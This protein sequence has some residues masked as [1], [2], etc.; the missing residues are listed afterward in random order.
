M[1]EVAAFG[2]GGD[3][4][5]S[6]LLREAESWLDSLA[7]VLGE[8][9]EARLEGADST[10]TVRAEVSGAGRLLGLTIDPRR[11]RD[12]DHV[13][14]AEAVREAIVAAHVAMGERLVEMADGLASPAAPTS[15]GD[16]L[17]SYVQNV[18]RGD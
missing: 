12:L 11:L 5:L 9:E 15:G 10:G 4:D 16:P 13:E 18:L 6:G 2:A 7:G 17:D 14:L 3:G 8:L 1:K